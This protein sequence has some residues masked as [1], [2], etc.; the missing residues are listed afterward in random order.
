MT[1]NSISGVERQYS[2]SEHAIHSEHL[3]G[4]YGYE[5]QVKKEPSDSAVDI[6][7]M[8]I[9]P[10]PSTENMCGVEVKF[11]DIDMENRFA[12]NNHSSG[13]GEENTL[14]SHILALKFNKARKM[15]RCFCF[16]PS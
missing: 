12:T 1:L 6:E 4:G 10:E 5:M 13:V 3:D 16:G 7:E 8:D 14:E 11:E 15:V 2:P 9:K